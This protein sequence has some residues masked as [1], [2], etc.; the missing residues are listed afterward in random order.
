MSIITILREWNHRR[1]LARRRA[2]RWAAYLQQQDVTSRVTVPHATR[3][4]ALVDLTGCTVAETQIVVDGLQ[5]QLH[6]KWDA[7]FFVRDTL[8]PVQWQEMIKRTRRLGARAHWL[9]LGRGAAALAPAWDHADCSWIALVHPGTV[10][11]PHAFSTIL[12]VAERRPA[13]RL[14]Y[15]DHDHIS[16]KSVRCAP[17]FKPDFNPEMLMSWNY[18]GNT[19]YVHK[20]EL[21][22]ECIARD[23][24]T[25]ALRYAVLLE[26]CSRLGQAGSHRV[27]RILHHIW[28]SSSSYTGEDEPTLLQARGSDAQARV[29]QAH[30]DLHH[31]GG[32][33]ELL[34]R[35]AGFRVRFPIPAPAPLVSILI[36]T[37]NAHQLVEQCIESLLKVTAYPHYE[38]ILIDN[39]SDDPASLASFRRLATDSRVRVVRDDRPFNY[40]ALNNGALPHAKGSL[41]LLLNNDTEFRSSEWLGEM[42]SLAVQPEIGCVGAKLFYPNGNIQH[43]G[44]ITGIGGVAGHAYVG[45]PGDVEGYFNRATL[46]H[47]ISVVTAACLMVRREVYEQVG[48][49]NER[50]LAVAYNDVDFCLRVREA[51]FRNVITPFAEAFHHET[52]TRGSDFDRANIDRFRREQAYMKKT[53]GEQLDHDPAYNPNL[54]LQGCDFEITSHPREYEHA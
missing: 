21:S 53:W 12:H 7:Y 11:A 30:V 3:I 25:D 36:P 8:P 49:L 42:V 9:D 50:D 37:R 52:A 35:H 54:T 24:E 4:C 15:S 14:L 1:L 6:H 43:V 26:T 45:M 16:V 33:V 20:D 18:I 19:F 28:F 47:A 40:S 23:G 5:Q 2:R 13:A 17:H 10:L 38:V 41:I 48:G 27:P 39:G 46:L 31:P 34:A 44:V 32:T 51:G 22:P 29:L